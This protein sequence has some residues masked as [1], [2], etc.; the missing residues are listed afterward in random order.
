VIERS[1]TP[2]GCAV[3]R[4][5]RERE[6]SLNVVRIC[7]AVVV[8]H[9]TRLAGRIVQ[10]IVVVDVARLARHRDVS[11]SQRKA[12]CRVIKRSATPASSRM[13]RQTGCGESGG[14]V[15]RAGRI[16]VVRLV[17]AVAV[18][19]QRRVV[20]VHMARGAGNAHVGTR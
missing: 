7:R 20:V 16:F 15:S 11:A 18:R 6:S 3:A 2:T 10:R 5:A 19:R 4:V 13:T 1:S 12:R 9:V 17:A 14:H 8:R